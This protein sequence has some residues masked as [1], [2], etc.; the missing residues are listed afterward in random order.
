MKSSKLFT[1]KQNVNT[2]VS[3]ERLFPENQLTWLHI[4]Y[5]AIFLCWFRLFNCWCT[6]QHSY[7]FIYKAR[8]VPLSALFQNTLCFCRSYLPMCQQRNKHLLA[9]M[10]WWPLL[11]CPSHT[12]S[13]GLKRSK[14][15]V[16]RNNERS[17]GINDQ[18]IY[19][20]LICSEWHF[21][22]STFLT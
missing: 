19:T 6:K 20:V 13:N 21:T 10:L 1:C 8:S 5:Q 3:N 18:I 11:R 14:F 2:C 9:S 15:Y 22:I 7:Q 12:V 4:G 16:C 17:Y